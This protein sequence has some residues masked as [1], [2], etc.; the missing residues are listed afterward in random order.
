MVNQ[1][2]ESSL[3]DQRRGLIATNIEFVEGGARRDVLQPT[4]GQIIDDVDLILVMTVNPGFGGQIFIHSQ[5]EKIRHVRKLIDQSGRDILL[6]VDGGI[7]P[8]TA[9]LAIKA[10]ANLL[11]A[12]TA[13]FKSKDYTKNIQDLRS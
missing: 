8:E 1:Y 11:V 9:P 4:A 10:G 13:V 2:V 12:G 5:L 6:E 7:T 3:L